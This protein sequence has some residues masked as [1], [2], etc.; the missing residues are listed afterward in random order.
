MRLI[1]SKWTNRVVLAL[2]GALAA[3]LMV[4]CSSPTPTA[5]P[6]P[7]TATPTT[8]PSVTTPTSTPLPTATPASAAVAFNPC[9][10]KGI[11][12]LT[13]A[14]ATFPYP[15]YSKVFDQYNKLC[16]VQV[17]YQSIGSGG[18]IAALQAQTVDFAGSDAVMSDAQKQQAKGGAVLHIPTVA[19][20]EAIIFNLPGIQRGQLKLT[21]DVLAD[22]YLKKIAKWNDARITALNPGL[23]LPNTDIAVV[24]RSDGSGTTFIFTNYLSKV[25]TEWSSK[26]GFA[27]S[28]NWP[29]DIGGQGNEGVANQVK[30]IPGA[31]GYVELAYALQN[32]MVW[33]QMKNKAGVYLEPSLDGASVAADVPS[34]PDNMQVVVTDSD[35]PKAYPIT[36]FTWLLVYE[37]Q[38]D[39]AKADA[40]ARLAWWMTH[41]GQQY[42]TPLHY[43]P[44]KGAAVTKVELLIKSIKVNGAQALP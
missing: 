20:A 36:G 34:L 24:H 19:G 42:T 33:A 40:V 17:N 10:T 38:A 16:G 25:S 31:I 26:V 27:T 41:D 7:P 23:A 14:G 32:N 15:L 44:L 3:G 21:S 1:K 39:P 6:V 18:G 43:A 9:P 11:K 30:Q 8:T 2:G 28:V 22:I 13:A 35:N 5:T 37:N 12:S 29:G 4:A